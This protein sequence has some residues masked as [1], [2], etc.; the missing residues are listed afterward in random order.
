MKNRFYKHAAP[1]GADFTGFNTARPL[2]AF[3]ATISK[4]SGVVMTQL[5]SFAA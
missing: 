4:T 1:L 3:S 5:G 2:Y